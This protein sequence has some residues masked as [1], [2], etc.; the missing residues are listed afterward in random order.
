MA[1]RAVQKQPCLPALAALE[2]FRL[3]AHKWRKLH[4]DTWQAKLIQPLA[5]RFIQE[6]T[7]WQRSRWLHTMMTNRADLTPANFASRLLRLC[8]PAWV[9]FSRTQCSCCMAP[10][11]L[12]SVPIWHPV[13]KL[14]HCSPSHNLTFYLH[15]FIR[16]DSPDLNIGL[17]VADS[18]FA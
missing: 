5:N 18:K 1:S 4:R 17:Q 10:L 6:V 13:S 3:P 7:N 2:C 9:H 16:K 15:I 12:L 8:C 14:C 11:T